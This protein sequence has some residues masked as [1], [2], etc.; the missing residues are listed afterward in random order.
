MSAPRTAGYVVLTSVA[1]V[2]EIIRHGWRETR[3]DQET[4]PAEVR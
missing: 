4:E 3:A 1:A 2:L